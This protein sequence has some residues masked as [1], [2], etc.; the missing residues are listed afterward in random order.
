[1]AAAFGALL[2]EAVRLVTGRADIAVWLEPPP[3]DW[4]LAGW[5]RPAADG[6]TVT[7]A[8]DGLVL[9]PTPAPH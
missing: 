7:V 4:Q 6:P 2:P 8:L 9:R 3:G 5:Q 1:V